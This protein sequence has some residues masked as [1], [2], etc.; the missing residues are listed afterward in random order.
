MPINEFKHVGQRFPD[1]GE[2]S[3]AGLIKIGLENTI[4]AV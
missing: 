1:I 3:Q 2:N 4:T